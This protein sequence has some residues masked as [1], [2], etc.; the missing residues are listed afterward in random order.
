[1]NKHGHLNNTHVPTDTSLVSDLFVLFSQLQW[2][3]WHDNNHRSWQNSLNRSG[4]RLLICTLDSINM[5]CLITFVLFL[6]NSTL[7]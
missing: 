6:F 3:V 4:T 7:A 2:L 5:N 1:M